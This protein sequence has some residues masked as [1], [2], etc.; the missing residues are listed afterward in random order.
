MRKQI[1]LFLVIGM[2]F[3]SNLF[4]QNLSAND[5]FVYRIGIG[6]Q[7]G[8]TYIQ[9]T[10]QAEYGLFIDFQKRE[11][12]IAQVLSVARDGTPRFTQRAAVIELASIVDNMP[13]FGVRRY[14]DTTT[15]DSNFGQL[16]FI[17]S[18]N[19]TNSVLYVGVINFW[20]IWGLTS[21]E[22][23]LAWEKERLVIQ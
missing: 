17:Q 7:Q 9:G 11:A 5:E 22:V 10:G 6:L 18:Q 14:I 15:L 23:F 16:I 13:I 20:N 1:L 8:N 21:F 12:Y 3:L 4:A 2:I 19:M